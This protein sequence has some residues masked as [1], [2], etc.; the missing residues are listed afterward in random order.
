M[1]PADRHAALLEALL[2]ESIRRLHPLLRAMR[3]DAELRAGLSA[4]IQAVLTRSC[5]RAGAA[6]W[7]ATCPELP[8]TVADLLAREVSI[9]DGVALMELRFRGLDPDCPFVEVVA[10]DFPVTPAV[11]PALVSAAREVWSAVPL[12]WLGVWAGPHAGWRPPGEGDLHLVVGALSSLS[13]SV[14][15][16]TITPATLDSFPRM[17][18]AYAAFHAERPDLAPHVTPI[19]AGE[20]DALIAAERAWDGWLEGEWAGL[21]AVEAVPLLGGPG[22][23]VV[24]EILA[25]HM[26]GRG[27]AAPLQRAGLAALT[28][29]QRVIVWGTIHE[30]NLPSRRTAA[31]VGRAEVDLRWMV[32]ISASGIGQN[33]LESA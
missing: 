20:L 15:P 30:K 24:E 1:I 13:R 21:L 16:L 9:G 5:S 33:N 7:K 29:R 8:A 28:D 22:A 10:T 27:L 19:D 6:Q 23:V 14:G 31:R 17:Q 32:P 4:D 11:L 26:R 12:R 18:A 3:S 25:P 2:P